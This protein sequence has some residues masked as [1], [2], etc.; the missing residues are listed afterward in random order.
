MI[1]FSPGDNRVQMDA[2]DSPKKF[3]LNVSETKVKGDDYTRPATDES[4][5]EDS[6]LRHDKG[7]GYMDMSSEQDYPNVGEI[8]DN[9]KNPERD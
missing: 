5:T 2:A 1:S 3:N 6:N 9:L 8:N 7:E 4:Q